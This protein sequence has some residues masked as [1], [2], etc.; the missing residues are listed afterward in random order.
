M[1]QELIET[2]SF[3]W[4]NAAAVAEL[5]GS[6]VPA[7]V[8]D[9]EFKIFV[10]VGLST[11]LNPWKREIW[12]IKPEPYWSE[13]YHREVQ[14]PTQIMIGINGYW[15]I[16]NKHP[17]FDGAESGLVNEAGELVKA[18]QKPIGAWCRI[19]R[20]SR[21]YPSEAV[22][23]L[24]E[25]MQAKKGSRWEKAPNQMILKVAESVALRKAFP[26]ELNGTYTDD[27]MPGEYA[28]REPVNVTPQA[29]EPKPPPVI[30][31]DELQARQ[32]SE[33]PETLSEYV[34][35]QVAGGEAEI[36]PFSYDLDP[37]F[38]DKSDEDAKRIRAYLKKA[39][40]KVDPKSGL[41]I[42]AQRIKKIDAYLSVG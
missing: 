1:N 17:D 22:V 14:P 20:K 21:K 23:Y 27:E 3:D 2:K 19:Y 15:Q 12:L 31:A 41:W 4:S 8:T 29:E 42:S 16:A 25:Y 5:K 33:P 34:D 40:A 39:G 32:A 13:K 6:I 24:S 36:L 18:C 35:Q 30:T 28:P 37:L 9:A 7:S 26:T 38:A 10:G 11:G